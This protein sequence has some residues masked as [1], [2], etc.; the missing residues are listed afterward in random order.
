MGHIVGS[1]LLSNI[2]IFPETFITSATPSNGYINPFSPGTFWDD[3]IA[4]HGGGFDGQAY[5]A[6]NCTEVSVQQYNNV[7]Q[8]DIIG[9]LAKTILQNENQ[10]LL[11]VTSNDYATFTFNAEIKYVNGAGVVQ[12]AN[13]IN[14]ACCYENGSDYKQYFTWVPV[15]LSNGKHGFF[16]QHFQ[17]HYNSG[18][19]KYEIV[20]GENS[21]VF[22]LED[23]DALHHQ[24]L[25]NDHYDEDIFGPDSDPEGYGEDG[26]PAHDHTSDTITIPDA[27][28]V[29]TSSVGFMHVYKV[30]SGALSTLGQYLFP[31][32]QNITDIESALRAIAGIFAY[33][34]SVQY[35]VDLHAI[36][37][38][39]SIGSNEFIKIGSLSTDISQPIVP[40]DY[41]DFDCGSK[42]I[43]EQYR[44]FIDYVGTRCKL[45]LPFVGFVE[46]APEY[47]NGGTI[48][49]KYRFNVIDGSFM[50]Y[51][52]STSSKSKLTNSL[53]GQYGGSACL[54]LPVIANSYGALA[55]GLV[56]GSMQI[57]AGA[58]TGNIGGVVT[59][60]MTA[61]NFQGNM[62]QSNNYNASTSYLGGRR[63]YFLIEREVPCFSAQYRHD[64][65]LP[66]NVSMTLSSLSGFTIIDDIDLSG[67]TGATENEIEELRQ[68][69]KEGVYF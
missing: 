25:L 69:L 54:H 26:T 15:N 27:P 35:I 4:Q 57:A 67:I 23:L 7:Q 8:G 3:I 16:L 37:V 46:I 24:S 20:S 14:M 58:A 38:S 13:L 48:S 6:D 50:A 51:V 32:A 62:S 19:Q 65:G 21:V 40:S 2:S 12:E 61:S 1:G 55:S 39:P 41:V 52:L 33:R 29:S 53:I 47:W 22:V 56:G 11:I 44:N 45:F 34:D 49:I 30:A 66:L 68:L 64:K 28:S 42:T 36:P 63:P 43:P 17:Y 31:S 59:G 18:E 60:A 5:I 10:F 9:T